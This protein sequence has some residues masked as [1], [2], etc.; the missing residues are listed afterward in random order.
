VTPAVSILNSSTIGWQQR[1]DLYSHFLGMIG[2]VEVIT[3]LGRAISLLIGPGL[4]NRD[5]PDFVAVLRVVRSE[6]NFPDRDVF[7]TDMRDQRGVS[8]YAFPTC[9]CTV[10]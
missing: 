6:E 2:I 5:L 9:A 7:S 8:A 4:R 10:E 1:Y 3:D